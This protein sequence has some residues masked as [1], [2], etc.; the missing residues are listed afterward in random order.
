MIDCLVDTPFSVSIKIIEDKKAIYTF[1][2][3]GR[4]SEMISRPLK[5]KIKLLSEWGVAICFVERRD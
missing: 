4:L 3:E 1:R 2:E 5:F